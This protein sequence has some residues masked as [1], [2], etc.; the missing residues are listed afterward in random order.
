MEPD[1]AAALA[2]VFAAADERR[3]VMEPLRQ[4]ARR[5]GFLTS[6]AYR[7]DRSEPGYP[8]LTIVRRV[9]CG[10]PYVLWAECKRENGRLSASQQLWR[11]ALEAVEERTGGLVAYRLARPS[12]R[13]A[14]E[15]LL[16]EGSGR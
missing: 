2:A 4:L 7:S 15:R 12:D 5:C 9:D 10:P 6:H 3:D 8:D 13:W 14:V 1:R 11:A 16:V